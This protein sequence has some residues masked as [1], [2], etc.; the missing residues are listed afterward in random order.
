MSSGTRL[1]LAWVAVNA[2]FLAAG[3]AAFGVLDETVGEQ[4]EV[5]DAVAHL[6]GLP[7]AAAIFALGQWLIL[8]RYVRRSGWAAAG[9][10]AGLTVG[11]L[12]GFAI[13]DGGADTVLGFAL[14]GVGTG[15]VQWLVL[16]RQF[17]GSGWWAAAST[18][19]FSVGGILAVGAAVAGLADALGGSAAA[20]V[21]LVTIF[22]IV[23]GVVGGTLTGAVLVRL[24]A[25]AAR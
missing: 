21:I 12:A 1:W 17:E 10:I 16:R 23:G 8:R 13:A 18:V 9:S 11:Y 2:L 6:V 20:Y 4:G 19:G 5:G 24:A 25:K 7:L 3:Q 14:M 22:G 15:L